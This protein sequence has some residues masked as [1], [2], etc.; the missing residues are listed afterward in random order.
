MAKTKSDGRAVVV[1]TEH[2]G[3]FFGY[4]VGEPAKEKVLLRRARNC[5]FWST[6]VLGFVG[7]AER[8]PTKSCRVGPAAEEMT[9]FGITSVLV[10]SPASVEAWEHSPWA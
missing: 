5:V 7:L 9:L 6:D 1:T 3:V 8:G 10:C 2:R 4:L